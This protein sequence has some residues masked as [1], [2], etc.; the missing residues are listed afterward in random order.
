METVDYIVIG[1]IVGIAVL[2]YVHLKGLGEP[3][4]PEKGEGLIKGLESGVGSLMSR[5]RT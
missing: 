2:V 1:L 4:E 5:F 3:E